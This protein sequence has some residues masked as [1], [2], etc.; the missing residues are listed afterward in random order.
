MNPTPE[1]TVRDLMAAD[2]VRVGP[3]EPLV[4]V[5]RRM[6][7]RRIGAVLVAEGDRLLGIFTERDLLRLSSSPA[8][9][10]HGMPVARWMTPDPYVID[11]DSGWERAM[12]MMD[13]LRVRHLPVV[14]G[15]RLIGIVSA[16]HLISRREEHLNALIEKRTRELKQANDQ[17]L[18]R[19]AEIAHTMRA[20]ARLQN[21]LLL[22][23]APP[24]WPG[25][26]WGICY[27]PLDPLGGDYYDFSRPDPDHLGILIADA[28]G[29]SIPAALVAIMAR[30]AFT[31][32]AGSTISPGEVLAAMN[33]RLQGLSDERFV[34]AFYGVLNRRTLRF[35]FASA[36][37]PAPVR[38]ARRT[39]RAELLHTRGFL[40]GI[41]PDEVYAE[42]SI[43]LEPGDRLL[44][45]TDGVTE[46]RSEIGETFGLPRLRDYAAAHG[47][48]RAEELAQNLLAHLAE[49]RGGRPPTDDLTLL[50]AEFDG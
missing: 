49:F 50:V 41:L 11:P 20:A 31:E 37:H 47:A 32:V 15:G 48:G 12:Q 30:I 3:E 29:H 39:A 1:L 10:W 5:L 33:R 46:S 38:Y 25:V 17:L 21:R 28:S 9:G 24:G 23:H 40:L 43:D 4:G 34:T 7:E 36:G 14:E 22:P 26:A 44:L 16:R 27:L 19:D 42:K 2:P 6:N 8:D 13:Q 35:T 18:A 45:Y